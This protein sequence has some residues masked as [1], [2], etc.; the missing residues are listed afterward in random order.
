MTLVAQPLAVE[1]AA[2]AHML[3]EQSMK[4]NRALVLELS[5][6][7]AAD[8]TQDFAETASLVHRPVPPENLELMMA[9]G[10]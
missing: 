2:M 1:Q 9:P 6:K 7:L 3:G 10:R 8:K 4:G 5:A